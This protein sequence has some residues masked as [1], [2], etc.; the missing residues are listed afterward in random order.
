MHQ[1]FSPGK[2]CAA[3]HTFFG[4]LDIKSFPFSL[5]E[6]T[7][8][9]RQDGRANAPASVW[10]RSRGPHAVDSQNVSVCT[11]SLLMTKPLVQHG[12]RHSLGRL[13][14]SI[15]RPISNNNFGTRASLGSDIPSCV[16]PSVQCSRTISLA[17]P[18]LLCRS[19]SRAVLTTSRAAADINKSLR[20][21]SLFSRA[22][23]T[24]DCPT[25][26]SGREIRFG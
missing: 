6:T 7:S 22:H 1:L 16:S 5:H 24:Q 8:H 12:G 13:L 23:I 26:N 17:I 19:A 9:D 20:L 18:S 3:L 4:D 2:H 11:F 10:T 25:W 21:S 15:D 14:R